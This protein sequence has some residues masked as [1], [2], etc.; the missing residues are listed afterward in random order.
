MFILSLQK[1]KSS[2]SCRLLICFVV[3]NFF[4][5]G[6]AS[7]TLIKSRPE[8]AEVYIDNVRKGVTPL[9]YSDTAIAGSSKTLK[10]KKKGY[11]DFETKLR[12][13]EFQVGPC[14]GGALVLFP[15]VWILGYQEEQ[16]FELEK[17]EE[18]QS[19][20]NLLHPDFEPIL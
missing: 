8:G 15:F 2:K 3:L 12:K 6:C 20:L 5:V 16:E 1:M 11:R 9:Q 4:A 10:L 18:K 7:K 13:S 19:M 17:L 14:I